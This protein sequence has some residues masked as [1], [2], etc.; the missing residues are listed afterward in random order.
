MVSTHRSK[1]NAMI[2]VFT[3]VLGDLVNELAVAVEGL[4]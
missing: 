4:T 1:G 2:I 3:G